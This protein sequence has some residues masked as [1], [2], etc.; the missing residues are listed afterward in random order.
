MA[1]SRNLSSQTRF[2]LLFSCQVAKVAQDA[3][4]STSGVAE[5]S[6]LSPPR[7][8]SRPPTSLVGLA[9]ATWEADGLRLLRP[10]LQARTQTK[11]PRR[12]PQLRRVGQENGLEVENHVRKGE[13]QVQHHGRRGQTQVRAGDGELQRGDS[14]SRTPTTHGELGVG[15]AQQPTSQQ[16]PRPLRPRPRKRRW[17]AETS[18]ADAKAR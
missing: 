17:E 10:G 4:R 2:L 18:T 8:G 6:Q 5:Q 15:R 11:V 1:K 9:T 16:R 7:S 13:T 3:A 12:D 14:E